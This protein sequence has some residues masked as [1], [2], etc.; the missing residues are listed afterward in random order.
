MATNTIV[1]PYVLRKNTNQRS[2][3]YGRWYAYAD[4]QGT[5]ST[6]GLAQHMIEHG[7][8]ADR[9]DVEAMLSKLS[10]CIPELVA[11]GYGVKLN[12]IGI[13]YPTIDNAKGGAENV[14]KFNQAEHISG[15]RFRFNADSTDLDNLTA[16]AFRKRVTLGNG[17]YVKAKGDKAPRYPLAAAATDPDAGG[18]TPEP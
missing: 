9:G 10:E 4:R 12:S 3:A 16:K 8:V 6:R 1:M 7:L 2:S 17:H 13:F 11:M 14:V 18:E 5:L 15:I